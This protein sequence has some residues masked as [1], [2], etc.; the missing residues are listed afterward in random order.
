MAREIHRVAWTVSESA[1]KE[2]EEP[3]EFWTRIGRT[4]LNRDG[5]ETIL[6]DALPTNA[7]IIL[8]DR[9]VAEPKEAASE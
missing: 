9:K 7:R 6:L 3:R 8:R 4:F 1:A 2:G 5:S